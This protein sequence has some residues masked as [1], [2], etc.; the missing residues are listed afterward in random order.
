MLWLISSRH[1]EHGI[2]CRLCVHQL[3][4]HLCRPQ[5]AALCALRQ[6]SSQ[7]ITFAGLPQAKVDEHSQPQ[8]HGQC[9]DQANLKTIL[10]HGPEVKKH[11]AVKLFSGTAMLAKILILATL[12]L[13]LVSLFSALALLFKTDDP[14]KQKRV[15]QALTVRISLSIGL[16]I[17]LVASFYFGLIPG[18]G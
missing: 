18:R 9:G 2:L 15:V 17:A 5:L 1:S 11:N 6:L 4:R 16:F 13:I 8:Q 14:D 10:E 7:T 12:A 3:P